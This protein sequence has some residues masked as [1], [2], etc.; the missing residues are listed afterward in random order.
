MLA[1]ACEL[2]FV[3]S[4][5]SGLRCLPLHVLQ[6]GDMT[7]CKMVSIQYSTA[8]DTA[9]LVLDGGGRG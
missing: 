5:C 1:S 9:N 2:D 7:A 3:V 4:A 6:L 8:F